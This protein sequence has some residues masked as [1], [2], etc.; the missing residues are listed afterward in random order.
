MPNDD[1]S[2][3]NPDP[4]H[5]PW[6]RRDTPS[7]TTPVLPARIEGPA[8]TTNHL[9]ARPLPIARLIDTAPANADRVVVTSMDLYGRLADR[10]PI[11]ALNWHPGTHIE[12]G[13][14]PEAGTIVVRRGG[15]GRVS[16]Q[17]RLR[18]PAHIRRQFRLAAGDRLLIAALAHHGLLIAHT[19][20]AVDRM[21]L[22]Y[23]ASNTRRGST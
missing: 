4:T 20:A 19:M 23:H 18:L 12:F 17:G 2:R 14:N 22:A 9:A 10:T 21:V 11:L 13:V 5:E 7:L 6:R 3:Q 15:T 16:R 1:M 8:K